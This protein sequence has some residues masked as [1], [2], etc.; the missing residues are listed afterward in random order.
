MILTLSFFAL[1]PNLASAQDPMVLELLE[2]SNKTN[3]TPEASIVKDQIMKA[4]AAIQK[5]TGGCVISSTEIEKITPSTGVR[6]VLEGIAFRRLRNG[7][8][9]EAKH[10][11][12]GSDISRYLIVQTSDG[13][14]ETIRMNKG[15]SNANES[16]I[17]DTLPSAYIAAASV[18][19]NAG[20][21]CDIRSAESAILG[22]T[23][24]ANEE[25]GLGP[26]VY[27]VRYTGSWTEIWPIMICNRTVEVPVRFTGD[28]DGGAYN[29]IKGSKAR[30]LPVTQ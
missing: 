18:I 3:P 1:T 21:K 6:Y 19:R 26:D 20:G 27:G 28:G 8:T 24:I 30:L 10:Q 5:R 9:V 12:C 15:R 14:L 11:N 29:D 25:P 22:T 16:L 4:A 7:W 17:S 13:S 2:K 23:R